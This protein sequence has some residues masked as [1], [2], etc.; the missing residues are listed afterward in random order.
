MFDLWTM[1]D[2]RTI[3][4]DDMTHDHLRNTIAMLRRR[5]AEMDASDTLG[6]PPN[7]PSWVI[8]DYFAG[9]DT[10]EGW[11]ARLEAALSPDPVWVSR[12][13]E[14]GRGEP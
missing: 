3:R 12:D 1:R 4:V 11:I 10:I 5:L 13:D 14:P 2:G 6:F 7:A 8:D 9:K